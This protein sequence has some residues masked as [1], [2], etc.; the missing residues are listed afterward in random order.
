MTA[1][2]HAFIRG[3]LVLPQGLLTSPPRAK[4][5]ACPHRSSRTGLH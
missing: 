5:F 1:D 3:F 2:T 4:L